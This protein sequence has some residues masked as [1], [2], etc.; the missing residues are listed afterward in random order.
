MKMVCREHLPFYETWIT[1]D[2]IQGR[3]EE[4][5]KFF[6]TP[7]KYCGADL[8]KLLKFKDGCSE[9]INN[10]DADG[11]ARFVVAVSG[12]GMLPPVITVKMESETKFASIKF[13]LCFYEVAPSSIDDFP[14]ELILLIGMVAI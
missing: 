13:S 10:L 3:P 9:I 1:D 8:V 7:E 14:V 11:A 6:V 12:A 5:K 2:R 4:Y